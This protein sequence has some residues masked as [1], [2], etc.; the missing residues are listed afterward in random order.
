MANI[1]APKISN[2]ELTEQELDKAFSSLKRN[3]SNGFDDNN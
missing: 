1:N 3:K 2:T